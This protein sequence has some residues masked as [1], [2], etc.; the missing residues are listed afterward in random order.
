M[1]SGAA[2]ESRQNIVATLLQETAVH[3]VVGGDALARWSQRSVGV[4]DVVLMRRP[5]RRLPLTLVRH[6]YLSKQ[7]LFREMRHKP[8]AHDAIGS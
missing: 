2:A 6:R 3:R 8:H 4:P 7:F 1:C 5:P